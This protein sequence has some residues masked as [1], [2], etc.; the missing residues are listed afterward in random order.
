MT[1]AICPCFTFGDIVSN[2]AEPQV[3]CLP[4]MKKDNVYYGCTAAMAACLLI[5]SCVTCCGPGCASTCASI[6]YLMAC[7]GAGYADA[8]VLKGQAGDP[9]IAT[10]FCKAI[11]CAS[12]TLCQAQNAQRTLK[13]IAESKMTQSTQLGAPKVMRM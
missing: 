12:C 4:P 7:A 11:F 5:P 8:R 10:N 2:L 1:T 3:P 6:G 9:G 13:A